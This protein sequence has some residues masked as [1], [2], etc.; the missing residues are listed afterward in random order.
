MPPDPLSSSH[1][2]AT[3]KMTMMGGGGGG[4]GGGGKDNG[5]D[6]EKKIN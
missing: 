6:T 4:G 3:A 5:G 1:V 2:D